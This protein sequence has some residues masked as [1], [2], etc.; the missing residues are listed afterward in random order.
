M[1]RRLFE[2]NTKRS[3]FDDTKTGLDSDTSGPK[4]RVKCI[5]DGAARDTLEAGHDNH[6][7]M[8]GAAINPTT[9][10]QSHHRGRGRIV[11]SSRVEPVVVE[12]AARSKGASPVSGVARVELPRL[13][14]VVRSRLAVDST[15]TGA[16]GGAT[17]AG[18]PSTEPMNRYPRRGSVSMYFGASAESPSASRSRLMAAFRPCSKSTNVF[19][20]HNRS[21]RSSRVTSSPGCSTSALRISID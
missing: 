5:I 3:P 8:E 21:R 15:G 20:G 11:R 18:L 4:S 6:A 19:A 17:N 2:R 13:G 1:T 10:A 16:C 12:G 14:E 7:V 9:A